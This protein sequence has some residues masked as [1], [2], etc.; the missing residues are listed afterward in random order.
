MFIRG[1]RRVRRGAASRPDAPALGRTNEGRRRGGRAQPSRAPLDDNRATMKHGFTLASWFL[2]TA[3]TLGP[4]KRTPRFRRGQA[5]TWE[6]MRLSRRNC[7]FRFAIALVMFTLLI[8]AIG[9]VATV[10]YYFG[11]RNVEM[12][13][14]NILQQTLGRVELRIQALTRQA[15]EQ[16]HL[17]AQLLAGGQFSAADFGRMEGFLAQALQVSSNLTYLGFGLESTGEYLMAERQT[18]AAIRVREYRLAA[19]GQRVIQDLH[20]VNGRLQAGDFAAARA[21]YEELRR[22]SPNDGVAAVMS[23][24]CRAYLL[25]PPGPEW[26]GVHVVHEK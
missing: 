14:V 20:L 12:L 16:N 6:P 19:G 25:T 5:L 9:A 21:L 24:R 10:S 22:H 3:P 7:T 18:N 2:H 13:A 4:P 8:A 11:R 23:E 1:K 17:H 15:A 26:N